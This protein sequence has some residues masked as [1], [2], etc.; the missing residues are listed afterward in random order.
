[1]A[2]STLAKTEWTDATGRRV[3]RCKFI[4]DSS[5]PST[6]HDLTCVKGA[7]I[8]YDGNEEMF[9]PVVGSTATIVVNI[10]NA[11]DDLYARV[12]VGQEGNYFMQLQEK[13]V[14]QSDANYSTF[15]QGIVLPEQTTFEDALPYSLTITASDDIG[16]LAN[17]P[18]L[19]SDGTR[20]EGSA[21]IRD[22]LLNCIKKLRT[23]WLWNDPVVVGPNTFHKN[24]FFYQACFVADNLS[25]PQGTQN[26]LE[27]YRV[28]HST[29]YQGQ[30][31]AVSCLEV[32]ENIGRT[33]NSRFHHTITVNAY[34][35]VF[36][37]QP[38]AQQER[39]A[40][41]QTMDGRLIKYDESVLADNLGVVVRD[42]STEGIRMAGWTWKY[43]FPLR[44]I[45][46]TYKF[47]GNRPVTGLLDGA[48]LVE[49]QFGAI[50]AQSVATFQEGTIFRIAGNY[51]M[52]WGGDTGSSDLDTWYA[53]VT[54]NSGTAPAQYAILRVRIKIKVIL[55]FN[56][57]E[58][59]YLT[60]NDADSGTNAYV[61]SDWYNWTSEQAYD[62]HEYSDV[63]WSETEGTYNIITP[64]FDA[65]VVQTIQE[66]IDI[67]T[68][69]TPT[70]AIADD[71]AGI[72]LVFEVE[73]LLHDYTTAT[74]NNDG[75][76]NVFPATGIH[77]VTGLGAYIFGDGRA[78]DTKTFTKTLDEYTETMDV[79]TL[80]GDGLF[81]NCAGAIKVRTSNGTY[82]D[83]TGWDTSKQ[84]YGD[85]I[86]EVAGE[87][88][89]RYKSNGTL[90]HHV[91]EGTMLFQNYLLGFQDVV[92]I[93]DT[94]G[95]ADVTYDFIQLRHTFDTHMGEIQ[96]QLRDINRQSLPN[97]PDDSV[98]TRNIDPPF[99]GFAGVPSN[100][101]ENVVRDFATQTA[102]LNTAA[103]NAADY[104]NA[105]AGEVANRDKS[106]QVGVRL[107][108]INNSSVVSSLAD[109]NAGEFVQTNG[110]G[111]LKF[112]KLR[113][114]IASHA[115]R[116]G[117]YIATN[118]YYGS[119]SY[120]WAYHYWSGSNFNNTS[121]NPYA[122]QVSRDNAHMMVVAAKD[123]A[124]LRI[125]G[126]VR[127]DTSS[128]NVEVILCK[129][130]APDGASGNMTMTEVGSEVVA[131]TTTDRHY[132]FDISTTTGCTAGQ[133]LCVGFA[134]KAKSN[135]TKTILATY[136]ISGE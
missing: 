67:I 98:R 56:S 123:Y 11:L 78:G 84:S 49:S 41:G 51:Q 38:I 64:P 90:G 121:G 6:N 69:P 22:H 74:N 107:L 104:A 44:Q 37:F 89:L 25:M 27:F 62:L 97:T 103:A 26:E 133:L 23:Y 76:T 43:D 95:A 77:Q 109:G 60:R 2:Q 102:T 52:Q 82:Q 126:S 96:L 92:R 1:M 118:F 113:T 132:D 105:F 31:E 7:V 119:T 30:D 108:H 122:L 91:R 112:S 120:G 66:Q 134:H 128:D 12:I 4:T 47:N 5:A 29:F 135:G 93:V 32:I 58:T 53:G 124:N 68:P 129:V 33:F 131:I 88:I 15:W 34:Q 63:S 17:I 71:D 110:Q 8:E 40:E 65:S 80:L 94:S 14:G 87:E 16:N 19:Q 75:T 35:N 73:P 50:A 116:V 79:E 39:K 57:A 83:S 20:F 70:T 130:D 9:D 100:H 21:H 106:G 45:N 127:N 10:G 111:V 3:F 115:V 61:Y 55:G 54:G 85:D 48:N 28:A 13:N 36:A 99:G 117:A 72:R 24:L 81:P 18:Y 59:Y 42:I 125:R 86:H 46:H 101:N 114:V 136:S